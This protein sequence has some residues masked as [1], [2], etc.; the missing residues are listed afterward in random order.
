MQ[1]RLISPLHYARINSDAGLLMLTGGITTS[2]MNTGL[3]FGGA[4]NI[5]NSVIGN[6]GT[7]TVTKDGAGTSHL[8]AR[9][10]FYT[11]ATSISA[12][13]LRI[14]N[15][16]SLGTTAAGTTVTATGGAL[17]LDGSGGALALTAE[18]ITLNGTGVSTGGGALA[19]IQGNNSISN[20][21]TL[22]SAS[23]IN[24][25]LD[26]LTLSRVASRGPLV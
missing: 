8:C 21:I 7:G 13:A 17:E 24:S 5:V 22:G 2:V 11:A 18:A 6:L 9:R 4:G 10:I 12:G 26:T 20:A 16:A 3:T 14:Q 23:R 25:D 1:A 15:V 19:Y